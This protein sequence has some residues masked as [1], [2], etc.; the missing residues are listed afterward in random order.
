M[1]QVVTPGSP[2]FFGVR[3]IVKNQKNLGIVMV[4]A[5]F[6]NSPE[7]ITPLSKLYFYAIA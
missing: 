3:E 4:L 5:I 1:T 2:T 6:Q 7:V